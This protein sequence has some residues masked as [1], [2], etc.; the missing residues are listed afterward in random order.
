MSVSKTDISQIRRYHNGDLTA[1]EMYEL[2]LRAQNDPFLMD[3]M[4]GMETAGGDHQPHLDEIDRLL[5]QRVEKDEKRVVPIF[6]FKYW[7]AAASILFTLGIGGWWLLRQSPNKEIEKNMSEQMAVSGPK[8]SMPPVVINHTKDKK[9]EPAKKDIVK[10]PVASLHRAKKTVAAPAEIIADSLTQIAANNPVKEPVV[11]RGYVKR[12]QDQTTGSSYIITGKEVQDNPVGNVEQLLQGKVAGLNIQN[13]KPKAFGNNSDV[14]IRG[15]KDGNTTYKD[16]VIYGTVIDVNTK[17]PLPGATISTS[18]GAI[19]QTD[20][21]GKFI[22]VL[23]TNMDSVMISYLSYKSQLL[24]LKTTDELKVGLT[25][26]NRSLNEVAIR[27]YVKRNRDQTTGSS[28]IITGKEVTDACKE[29]KGFKRRFFKKIGF[30]EK[31]M[32]AKDAGQKQ[33]VSDGKFLRALK[34]IAKRTKVTADIKGK[35]GYTDLESYKQDK[36][37]WLAWYEANKCKGL[38]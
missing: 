11:I 18:K 30:V 3:A 21:N 5:K 14:K 35:T 7:A 36:I 28:Y 6:R 23:P 34:F 13:D 19:T 15:L 12:N 37:A 1:R 25:P 24:A 38:K 17:E 29:N 20:I 27:G 22:A 2:E 10:R 4:T 8:K 9:T 32:L 31:Y 26:E 33:T 16:R